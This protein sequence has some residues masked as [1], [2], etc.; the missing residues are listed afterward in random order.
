MDEFIISKFDTMPEFLTSYDLIN[1]GLFSNQ[2][3]TYLARSQGR[4][5][6]YIKIGRRIFYPKSCLIE[7]V[8]SHMHNGSM[9][10]K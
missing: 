8:K 9:P 7:W 2:N 10:K 1:L 6:S 5:P 4:S 3:G